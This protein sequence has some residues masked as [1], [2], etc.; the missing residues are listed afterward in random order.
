[1]N[2]KNLHA[3][4]LVS[5]IVL[6]CACSSKPYLSNLQATA[7]SPLYATYAAAMERSEFALDEGYEFQYYHPEHPIQFTTDTGGDIAIGF[8]IFTAPDTNASIP[9]AKV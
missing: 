3:I 4:T 6:L 5:V 1:M 9:C 7:D 8:K 2:K